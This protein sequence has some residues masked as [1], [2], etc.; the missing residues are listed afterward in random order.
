MLLPSVTAALATLLIPTVAAERP[1]PVDTRGAVLDLV[2]LSDG[3]DQPLLALVRGA[4]PGTL[5]ERLHALRPEA[6]VRFEAL[7]ELGAL[8]ERVALAMGEHG[9]AC[10]L[11][12]ELL[13]PERWR[14]HLWGTCATPPGV[15]VGSGEHPGAAVARSFAGD[16]RDPEQLR[17]TLILAVEDGPGRVEDATWHVREGSGYE[18]DSF[19]FALQ[20]G[21]DLTVRQLERERRSGAAVTAGLAFAGTAAAVTGLYL[22]GRGFV[23]ASEALS[24]EDQVRFEQK[25]W[26]G[27]VF[28][29]GGG[30]AISGIPRLRRSLRQRWERPDRLWDRE[31]A[32]ALIDG[33][34]RDLAWELGVP[35]D[36]PRDEAT[37]GE[38]P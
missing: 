22:T 17:D 1:E 35:L 26:T 37:P 34:N 7:P 16:E 4:A 36:I 5:D 38:Q 31:G 10:A 12:L 2:I 11:S 30:F 27:V 21:D 25:A 15:A 32:Q 19:R 28:M 23:Q 20:V 13:A 6:T 14:V 3:L 33:Y 24:Y 18:L 8:D 9:A 29:A